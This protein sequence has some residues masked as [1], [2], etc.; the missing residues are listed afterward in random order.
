MQDS[1]LHCRVSGERVSDCDL[2]SLLR[3]AIEGTALSRVYVYAV[4]HSF[5]WKS[6]VEHDGGV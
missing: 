3:I 4:I 6:A 2:V 5:D 1:I